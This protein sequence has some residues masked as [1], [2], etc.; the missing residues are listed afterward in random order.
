MRFGR[1]KFAIAISERCLLTILLPARDGRA[2]LVPNLQ[3][4][5]RSL[6]E[7]LGV[8]EEQVSRKLGAMQPV[9]FAHASNR[10][11]FG[12]MNDL[13][14]Q[15]SHHLAHGG[16]LATLTVR[17]AHTHHVRDRRKAGPFWLSGHA[18]PRSACARCG[19]T[20]LIAGAGNSCGAQPER[21]DQFW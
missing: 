9:S 5:P 13:A 12:S 4:S 1:A 16:D 18:R 20:L 6:L 17:L 19:L 14:F 3:A 7:R 2:S 8:P 15:A 11:V 21:R 10:R